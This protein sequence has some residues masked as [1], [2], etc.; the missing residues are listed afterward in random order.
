MEKKYIQNPKHLK[1][2]QL[3]KFKL[4]HPKIMKFD[5]SITH[6]PPAKTRLKNFSYAALEMMNASFV[7][8]GKF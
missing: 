4:Q 6:I 5:V 7:K 3:D 2:I 8:D 1:K